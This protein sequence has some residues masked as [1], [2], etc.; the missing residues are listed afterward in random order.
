M[1]EWVVKGGYPTLHNPPLV[2]MLIP[3]FT[4]LERKH[5]A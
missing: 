4:V 3:I 2:L 5:E 1:I